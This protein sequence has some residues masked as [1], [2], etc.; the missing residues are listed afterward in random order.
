M[1]REARGRARLEKSGALRIYIPKDLVQ[2]NIFPFE[3]EVK[4]G[5]PFNVLIKIDPKELRLIIERYGE[6]GM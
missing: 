6:G 5:K 1:L 2:S 3:E 4:A